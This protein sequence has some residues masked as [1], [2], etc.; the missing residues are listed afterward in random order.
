MKFKPALK[1]G[2]VTV[3]MDAGDD[4]LLEKGGGAAKEAPSSV[5]L[6]RILVPVDFSACSAK[7]LDY[8]FGLAEKF[9]ATLIL[10]HIVE[11]TPYPENY[12][13]L[14]Q[15]IEEINQ[16]LVQSARER[17]ELLYHKRPCPRPPVE[18]LVRLGHAYSEI[19]DTAQALA[20]DLIVVGTHG[21]TGLKHV[22]LGSTAE[23]VVRQAPCP[24]LTVRLGANAEPENR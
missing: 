13:L 3:E 14:P 22:L 10:L 1:P 12:M 9:G 8:A 16:N 19:S 21:H 11:P 6:K 18:F 23:K 17:L 20:A 5:N 15:A 2:K 24:V 4:Q 7:A